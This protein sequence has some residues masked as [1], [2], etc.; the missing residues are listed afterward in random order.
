MSEILHKSSCLKQRDMFSTC[1]RRVQVCLAF[2]IGYKLHCMGAAQPVWADR[3]FQS[4]QRKACKYVQVS[5]GY[6]KRCSLRPF[7]VYQLTEVY[8]IVPCH[9]PKVEL[10]AR[11]CTIWNRFW[12]IPSDLQAYT[13]QLLAGCNANLAFWLFQRCFFTSNAKS[14]SNLNLLLDYM[15]R[16]GL[17]GRSFARLTRGPALNLR[18]AMH[19]C[20]NPHCNSLQG[21]SLS[22]WR[23]FVRQLSPSAF[24]AGPCA[25]DHEWSALMLTVAHLVMQTIPG[26][27]PMSMSIVHRAVI[28][29]LFWV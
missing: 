27:P 23:A 21:W 19:N 6:L 17:E 15:L 3:C 12:P 9:L 5:L 7:M 8:C 29:D 13:V 26:I 20:Q 14:A 4:S 16:I 22:V 24:G 1:W 10:F 18:L 28:S 25:H 2:L 11:D